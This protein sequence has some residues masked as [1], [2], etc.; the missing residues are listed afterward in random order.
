MQTRPAASA[1]PNTRTSTLGYLPGLDG[2][3]AVSVLAV[4]AFHHYFI[5]GHEQGFAPGRLPR[6]RGV[7][8]RQ[9]LPH[10][11]AAPRRAPRDRAASRSSASGSGGPA[12]C[13]PALFVMLAVVVLYAL[14]FLPDSIDKL[15]SDTLAALTLHEQLVAGHLAP[16]VRVG[17]RAARRCSSISGHSR[18]KS[19]STCSGRRCC[20]SGCASSG[21]SALLGTMVGVALASS[22]L[23]A[24]VVT[25]Q[26]Q[27][28]VLLHDTRLVGP[29]ARFGDGVLLRAVPNPRAARARRARR[30]RRRRARSA[31]SCCSGRSRTSRSRSLPAGDLSVFRGGFLLVDIATLLVIAAVVH[32]RSDVG[33]I[34]GCAPLRW[35]GVRSYSLYLWHYPIFCVTRPGLDVPLHGW[36]PGSLRLVLSF[37]A[38]DLSYRYVET[39]IRE[40]RDR[41]VPRPGCGPSTASAG[42]ARARAGPGR[43][44]RRRCSSWSAWAPA[45]PRAQGETADGYPGSSAT[46]TRA[47]R[48]TRSTR[49][50]SPRCERSA[51]RPR[52][53]RRRSDGRG[54]TG[55][56]RARRSRARPRGDRC[57]RHRRHDAHPTALSQQI[58]AIGDSVMLGAEQSL[59][60]CDP[61][62]LRRRE[63]QPAVLGRDRRAA[64]V[65]ERE[66]APADRRRPHGNQRRV[67]RRAVRP[68]DG[69]A[70]QSHECSSST[71]ASRARGRPR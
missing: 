38:A 60:H 23:M 52:P 58:L 25:R 37:G 14:L 2:L 7:L 27:R 56:D 54:G 6:R 10:H 39:P 36:R 26:H 9:R 21:A 50:R 47:T 57:R 51:T 48:A 3:R 65:Q 40:R 19:S 24:I 1:R 15:K 4:L 64:G 61:R 12:G 18:S 67:Q 33:P 16:V 45:S 68:D 22:V 53:R 66:A 42:S 71:R 55:A 32:P 30:A 5:G 29:P 28:R 43:S 49:R 8:R 11:V 46:R 41:P 31:C 59:Q 62:D 44:W 13:C 70:R 20:C 34:L 63:G 69:G 17:G 35:I